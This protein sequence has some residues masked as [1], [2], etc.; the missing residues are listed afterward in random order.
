MK[1]TNSNEKQLSIPEIITM[2][3]HQQELGGVSPEAAILSVTR[4]GTLDSADI[5]HIGN[6]VFIGHR[7]TGAKQHIMQGRAFNVDT[8]TNF[9]KNGV[10]YA[11][12]LQDKGVTHYVTQYEYPAYDALFKRIKSH[13]EQ[14]SADTEVHLQKTETGKTAVFFIIGKDPIR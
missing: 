7:G 9:Y 12:R 3:A 14:L 4:E 10:E 2:A 5:E 13:I 8:A 6:T 11:K 1:T